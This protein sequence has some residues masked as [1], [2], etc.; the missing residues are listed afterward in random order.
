ML[1]KGPE[2]N[3]LETKMDTEGRLELDVR[4]KGEF[5]CVKQD[6]GNER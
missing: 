2:I 4:E 5:S 1:K 6:I 3:G